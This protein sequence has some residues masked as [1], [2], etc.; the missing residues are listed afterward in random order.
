ML[1]VR[2]SHRLYRI[3]NATLDQLLGAEFW[4]RMP[5]PRL[6]DSVKAHYEAGRLVRDG[7]RLR[8]ASVSEEAT[9]RLRAS[10]GLDEIMRNGL[11]AIAAQIAE[12]AT[13]VRSLREHVELDSS[14]ANAA[15]MRAE[16]EMLD[17]T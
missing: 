17:S 2:I 5:T 13:D 15:P 11:L 8:L 4:R 9:L 12:L 14:V 1:E 6:T 3:T 16:Q 7:Q 10:E